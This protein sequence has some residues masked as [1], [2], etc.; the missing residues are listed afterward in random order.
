MTNADVGLPRPH[1]ERAIAAP[2]TRRRWLWYWIAVT[3]GGL[4]LR[5]GLLFTMTGVV[6]PG[7]HDDFVRW[8]MQATDR[9]LLTLYSEPPARHDL[10]EW[11]QKERRWHIRQRRTDRVCNYPPGAAYLLYASGLVFRGVSRERLTNTPTSLAT[12]AGWGILAD[13]L[14]AG[15]CAAIVARLGRPRAARLTYGLMLAAPPFWWDSVGWAQMDTVLLAPAAWM[16]YTM[17]RR[18]WL[19]AGILW[20]VMLSLKPQAILFLPVWAYAIIIGRPRRRAAA[21]TVVAAVTLG[22][23]TLPFTL[24]SGTAWLRLSYVDNLFAAYTHI[25]TLKAF[26]IW[27]LV[28]LTSDSLDALDTWWGLT[29]A[30]WGKIALAGALL[31]GLVV[32]LWRFGRN[33][34]GL[35][36][37]TAY[38]LLMC[39]LLPTAVHER[40]LI[41]ALPF[42]GVAAAL[43]WRVWPGLLIL[44]VVMMAQL[45][46][47]LWLASGRGDWDDIR[48]KVLKRQ[49]AEWAAT[50]PPESLPAALAE[51]LEERHRAYRTRVNTTLRWEWTFT[52]LAL[53]G[54]VCT[55]AGLFAAR[56][57]DPTLDDPGEAPIASG[58]QTSAL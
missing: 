26:N 42:V 3:L 40:Y 2:A 43:S 11:D 23:I 53:A 13:I 6:Y 48:L 50:L 32:M 4:A 45:S 12:F 41:L 1:E 57:R 18:R 39:V 15:A 47:P 19:L 36:A 28:L 27:Y 49:D 33:G 34:Y 35:V 55:V 58:Y 29:K 30:A 8:G 24:S 46:W 38:V 51:V 10:R 17:L 31:I 56:P 52:V 5:I 25:S 20:G 14:L 21:G 44:L 16:V 7:D 37:W 54:T 22:V 9:G